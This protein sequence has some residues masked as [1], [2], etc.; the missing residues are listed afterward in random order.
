MKSL[1]LCLTCTPRLGN[2]IATWQQDL[3]AAPHQDDLQ[4]LSLPPFTFV[5]NDFSMYDVIVAADEALLL[6]AILLWV[7]FFS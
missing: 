3:H 5:P 4:N 2:Q 6:F 7:V 1:Q